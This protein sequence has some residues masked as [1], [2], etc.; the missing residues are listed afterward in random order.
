L[1]ARVIAAEGDF[2]QWQEGR[3]EQPAKKGTAGNARRMAAARKDKG[4]KVFVVNELI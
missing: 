2:D 4:Y 3:R 1:R